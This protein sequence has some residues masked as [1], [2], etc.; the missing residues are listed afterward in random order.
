[1]T[2]SGVFYIPLVGLV[3]EKKIYKDL[4]RNHISQEVSNYEHLLEVDFSEFV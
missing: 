3:T 4:E 1:M 2:L